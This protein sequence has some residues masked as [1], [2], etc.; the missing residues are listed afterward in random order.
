MKKLALVVLSLGFFWSCSSQTEKATSSKNYEEIKGK[1][2]QGNWEVHKEFDEHG[3][4]IR[5][6][7]T[8]SYSWSSVNGRQ[9]NPQEMDSLMANAR[10]MMQAHMQNFNSTGFENSFDDFFGE[11][12]LNMNPSEMRKKMMQRMQQMQAQFF[13]DQNFSEGFEDVEESTS[14]RSAE[15]EVETEKT[16]FT[17]S[18]QQI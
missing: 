18:S 14:E 17:T 9:V 13:G 7:S 6:D 8:Y 15:N 12:M 5:K 11:S 3:N 4:L 10:K 1:S 16:R 2:P